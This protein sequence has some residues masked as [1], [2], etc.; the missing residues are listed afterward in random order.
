MKP[1]SRWALASITSLPVAG[2]I[3]L[4]GRLEGDRMVAADQGWEM[5][6]YWFPLVFSA[7]D[8]LLILG[9]VAGLVG[10]VLGPGVSRRLQA[11]V[12][13]LGCIGSLL[14]LPWRC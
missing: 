3:Y 2:L 1:V 6:F 4:L 14:A 10:L 8:I 13:V 5:A 12:A 7:I 9:I 11:G